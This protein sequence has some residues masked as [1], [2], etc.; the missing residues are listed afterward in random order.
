[1]AAVGRE[2]LSW[3]ANIKKALL[4]EVERDKENYNCRRDFRTEAG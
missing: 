4:G 2:I 1:M 3:N